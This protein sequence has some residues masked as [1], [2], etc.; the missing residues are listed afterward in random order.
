M[1]TFNRKRWVDNTEILD[2]ETY[3]SWD[4]AC[5]FLSDFFY[6]DKETVVSFEERSFDNG[7]KTLSLKDR[8]N[9]ILY[10]LKLVGNET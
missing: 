8:H 5:K 6:N 2:T 1:I 4:A 10:Q 7:S 9:K 3:D